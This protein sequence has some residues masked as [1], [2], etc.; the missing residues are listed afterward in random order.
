MD[1]PIAEIRKRFEKY[2]DARTEEGK[3]SI[4]FL[5]SSPDGFV[6]GFYMERGSYTVAFEGWHEHF[7]AVDEAFNCFAFGLSDVCRLKIVSRGGKAHLWI[8]E[9][10]RDGTW[11]PDG[12]TGL[13]LFQ[14]W[15]S[16]SV[17]YR[18]NALIKSAPR[19]SG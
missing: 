13:L 18:Q 19:L 15:R 1:D 12:E 16:P 6:V 2:P 4:R 3:G 14:F 9:Q 17:A 7:R 8:V 10:L 5:P 11:V